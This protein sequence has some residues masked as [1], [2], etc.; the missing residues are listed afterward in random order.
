MRERIRYAKVDYKYRLVGAYSTFIEIRPE[1]DIH[2]DGISLTTDGRLTLEDGFGWDGASGPAF[3]TPSFMRPSA[4]HD[5]IYRL[6]RLGLLPESL[7]PIAD[8]IM[9]R[10]CKED[11]MWA[12]RR[13]WCYWAVRRG[14]AG[15]AAPGS[16]PKPIWAP[17]EP[18]EPA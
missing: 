9:R 1:R 4:V 14:A 10:M 11:G 5:A 18:M 15:A 17:D 3:D 8:R 2:A 13:W 6:M 7:R 12:P 16:E